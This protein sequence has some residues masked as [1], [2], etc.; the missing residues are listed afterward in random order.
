MSN[1]N[2]LNTPTNSDKVWPL[3]GLVG[4][5]IAFALAVV[6]SGSK[7]TINADDIKAGGGANPQKVGLNS[8]L[9]TTER[10]P[11]GSVECSKDHTHGYPVCAT[12][13]KIMQPLANGLFVCPE[14]GKIGLPICPNCGGVMTPVPPEPVVQAK[15]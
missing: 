4:I 8:A 14:C 7:R 5:V 15:R 11:E 6:L 2:N 12:C 1:E 10:F 9:A 13:K 3:L